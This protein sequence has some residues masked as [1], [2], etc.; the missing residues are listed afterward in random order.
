M[1]IEALHALE[2][3][4]YDVVLLDVRMPEIDGLDISSHAV[5]IR[6]QRTLARALQML[7]KWG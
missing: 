6:E 4:H 1:V 2:R 5:R 7:I 3:Q